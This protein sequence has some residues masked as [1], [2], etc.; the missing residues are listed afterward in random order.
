M[1][2]STE[3]FAYNFCYTNILIIISYGFMFSLLDY[4]SFEGRGVILYMT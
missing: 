1:H 4:K 3:E 2:N